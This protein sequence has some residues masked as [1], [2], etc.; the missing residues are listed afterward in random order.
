[1]EIPDYAIWLILGNFVLNVI[2]ILY[3]NPKRT[4]SLV[5]QIWNEKIELEDLNGE[6]IKVPITKIVKDKD[7]NEVQSTEMVVG[8][9]WYTVLWGAGQM[10]ATQVKMAVLSGKGKISRALNEAALG[11]EAGALTPAAQA[12]IA[13]LPRKWQGPALLLAQALQGQG[14]GRSTGPGQSERSGYSPGI[15]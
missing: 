7:G 11:G 13:G 12:V 8:P 2:L 5:K 4:H 9:L 6:I 3:L 1:M 10:A 14:A 15:K